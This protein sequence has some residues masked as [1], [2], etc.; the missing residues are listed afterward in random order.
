[1]WGV[2][3]TIV[4]LRWQAAIWPRDVM[5]SLGK[6]RYKWPLTVRGDRYSRLADAGL[7]AYRNGAASRRSV[8]G[9]GQDLKLMLAT[10]D[11]KRGLAHHLSHPLR[12]LRRT[13]GVA[14]V[15]R[16]PSRL[17][18]RLRAGTG[19]GIQGRDERG[20]GHR[21][22]PLEGRREFLSYLLGVRT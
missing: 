12:V 13:A 20:A 9:R 8:N 15:I 5:P 7:A 18:G 11:L 22:V 21:A 17:L 19:R 4:P 14:A 3:G 10:N 2:W 1:M 16:R 6:A